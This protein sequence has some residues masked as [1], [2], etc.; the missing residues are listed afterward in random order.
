MVISETGQ[1]LR[2][3]R[4][5]AHFPCNKTR[6]PVQN[7]LQWIK[8]D[9]FVQACSVCAV[10]SGTLPF[11]PNCF[12]PNFQLSDLPSLPC[13]TTSVNF[14]LQKVFQLDKVNVLANSVKS[15]IQFSRKFSMRLVD[16]LVLF[17]INYKKYKKVLLSKRNCYAFAE[18]E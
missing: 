6:S 2:A 13:Y 17:I 8:L 3:L 14:M 7:R 18:F 9:R 12:F 4:N 15:D 11:P 16:L 5:S 1:F 10:P